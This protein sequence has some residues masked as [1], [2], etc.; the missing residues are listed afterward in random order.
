MIE[1]PDCD[2]ITYGVGAVVL[3]SGLAAAGGG[4]LDLVHRVV[5]GVRV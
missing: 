1:R 4:V 2:C 3:S 5:R